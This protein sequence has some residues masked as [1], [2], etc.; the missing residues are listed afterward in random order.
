[1]VP[2]AP[3]VAAPVVQQSYAYVVVH[4]PAD[5]T[6]ILGGNQTEMGGTVRKF[7]IP[8]SSSSDSYDYTVRAEL[9]RGGQLYVAQSTEKL[10]AGQT[11]SIKVNDVPAVN[12]AAR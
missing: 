6:L 3:V 8:V 5:A 1:M 10:V 12:V 2:A 11:V 9:T 7:K 4:V